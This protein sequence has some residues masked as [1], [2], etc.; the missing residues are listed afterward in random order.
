MSQ[1]AS[2]ATPTFEPANLD[3]ERVVRASFARQGLMTTIGARLVVV[4]PG[5]VEIELPYADAI[6][7]QGGLFH[8]GIIGA[9]ADNAGGYAAL[10]LMPSGSEVLTVEYKVNFMRPAA[11]SLLRATGQ[12]Q[13]AGRTMSVVRA[14]VAC[15]AASASSVCALMQATMMRMPE[16]AGA[17]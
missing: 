12:V 4:E 11:G 6:S 8:G 13:R 3:F 7:Q 5:R 2:M 1:P 10:S 9:I 17:P 15:I 16:N 14:D